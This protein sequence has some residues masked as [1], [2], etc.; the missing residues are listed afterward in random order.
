LGANPPLHVL[1]GYVR[2]IWKDL[3]INKVVM[4]AKGVFLLRFM[5]QNAR[6]KACEMNGFMFDKKPFIVK[7]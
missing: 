7:P 3:G 5:E 4:V 6:E 1:D 2:R